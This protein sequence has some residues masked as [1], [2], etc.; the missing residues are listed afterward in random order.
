[1]ALLA[2]AAFWPV[3]SGNR[4][5]FHLDLRNEHLPVWDVT[6]KAL[7]ARESPFWIDGEY[8]GHPLLFTQEAPVFYPL[9]I[10]LLLTGAPVARLADLFSLFHFWLA[11]FAAFLLL[12]DLETGPLPAV[13]GGVAWMLSARLLQSAIWPNAVAVSAFLPLLLLGILRIAGGQ[14]RFSGV[15]V[16]AVAGGLMIL[17]SR[18]QALLGAAPL[19][20]VVTAVSLV[21]APRRARAAADLGLA[22]LFALALGAPS[23]L[24][25]AALY[26]EMS[27]VVGLSQAQRDFHPIRAGSNLDMVFLPT[28]GGSRWPEAAAYPGAIIEL[29]FVLG[30]ALVLRRD[31]AFTQSLFLALLA[32]G[33][34]G[35]V[36]AFGEA[37]PY[38]FFAN[39]PLIRGFRVPARYLI[40]WSLALAIGSA[41]V[42][43]RLL[44]GIS[45]PVLAGGAAVLLLSADLS[46]HALRSAPTSPAA[47]DSVEPDIVKMLRARLGRDEAGFPRRFWPLAEWVLLPV[48]SDE[49]KLDVARRYDPLTDALGMRFGLESVGGGGPPLLATEALLSRPTQQAAMLTGAGFVVL[50]PPR[51]QGQLLP[52]DWTL[53][54]VPPFPR[55]LLVSRAI[56]VPP[57]R[58]AATVLAPAFDPRKA[59]LVEGS[60]ALEPARPEEDA[61]SVRL[62]SRRPGR[63][64]LETSAPSDRVLVLFDAWEKG[65][66]AR[67]DG[68]PSEVF[69]A[70][71]AFR[72]VRLA[73]GRHRVL[74]EYRAPGVVEGAGLFA[75]GLLGLALFVIRARES[76]R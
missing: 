72:G 22:A 63:V 52:S 40:S 7:R 17:A 36:F 76:S 25:S 62:V 2:S 53:R 65:W 10:P 4:T 45:R 73:A 30:I 21:K 23:L 48:Y 51:P 15:L 60:E 8:C 12:E 27:R 29:L 3:V 34:I 74:F 71:A 49:I 28:D 19:I 11:G 42:L 33:A 50:S 20:F 38:R 16:A 46:W 13:F 41:L 44:R 35:L 64:E 37:G 55:A 32:G 18:P 68:E 70:D 1:M 43:S 9:T 66:R 6:Q 67:V 39:L 24:P 5:F 31:R 26:P 61:G 75:A 57:D 54:A 14:R 58:A 69:R 47:L 56:P 59:V